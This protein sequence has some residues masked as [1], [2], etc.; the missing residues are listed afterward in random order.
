MDRKV[1]FILMGA[2]IALLW[3][4]S[5]MGWH[6]GM[7]RY[8]FL[9][10]PFLFFLWFMS[11]IWLMVG[12]VRA[13]ILRRK[14]IIE[15]EKKLFNL[16][17]I[18]DVVWDWVLHSTSCSKALALCSKEKLIAYLWI[19]ANEDFALDFFF[20]TDVLKSEIA[21]N[22]KTVS[23]IHICSNKQKNRKP[24][25]EDELIHQHISRRKLLR[26]TVLTLYTKSAE[27]DKISINL[28][29]MITHYT[30]TQNSID[31][32]IDKANA[33]QNWMLKLPE[34]HQN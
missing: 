19:T 26:G 13:K 29:P 18:Q 10:N 15:R 20:T 17:A 32:V 31:A 23:S 14:E 28:I 27:Y 12:S 8:D 3:F 1:Q 33:W 7:N 6:R 2:F 4:S 34:L 22:Y 16:L 9:Q 24:L 30:Q 25:H 11:A 5:S 21:V